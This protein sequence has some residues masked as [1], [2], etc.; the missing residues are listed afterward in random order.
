[1]RPAAIVLNGVAIDMPNPPTN[2]SWNI[3]VGDK[4]QI[5][6]AG[7]WYTVVGPV[8]TPNPGAIH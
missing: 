8:V 6:Q 1:M 4:L 5:N 2:W 3:R 7:P